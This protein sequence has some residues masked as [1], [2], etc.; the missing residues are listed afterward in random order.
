MAEGTAIIPGKELGCTHDWKP[1]YPRPAG[2]AAALSLLH[3]LPLGP[4]S[5]QPP[6]KRGAVGTGES[7]RT[8]PAQSPGVTRAL[9]GS[10]LGVPQPALGGFVDGYEVPELAGPPIPPAPTPSTRNTTRSGE[11]TL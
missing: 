2:L 5:P 6:M 3:T 8:L 11:K 4:L 9:R 10:P 7:P 1:S